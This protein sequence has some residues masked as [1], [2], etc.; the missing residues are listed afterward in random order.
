MDLRDAVI[1]RTYTVKEVKTGDEELEK[2]P[3]PPRMLQRRTRY[4]GFTPQKR[5]CCFY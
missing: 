2:F 1:G 5:L 4:R 3:L